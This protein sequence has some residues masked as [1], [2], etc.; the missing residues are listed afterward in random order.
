MLYPFRP[1]CRLIFRSRE[2]QKEKERERKKHIDRQT[3]IDIQTEEDISTHY[4]IFFIII[5]KSS[6]QSLVVGCGS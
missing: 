5:I 6:V 2:K 1:L 4:I 3:E